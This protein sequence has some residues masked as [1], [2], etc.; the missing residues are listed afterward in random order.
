MI[1]DTK[2]A[3]KIGLEDC[4]SI[5]VAKGKRQLTIGQSCFERPH[6]QTQNRIGL[7]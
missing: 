3:R 1:F 5:H 7:L 6:G 2:K 4:F